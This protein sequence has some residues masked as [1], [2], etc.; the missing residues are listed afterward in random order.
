MGPGSLAPAQDLVTFRDVAVDFTQEEWGLLD[1]L[2]KK[3]YKEV[4]LENAQNLLSLGLPV[5]REDM[6]SYFKQREA[7]WLLDQ[8]GLRRCSL[9]REIQLEMTES[10]H[11]QRFMSPCDFVRNEIQ[12]THEKLHNSEKPN[13]CNQCGKSFKKK[14]SL[15]LHQRIHTGEKLYECNLCE[16]TFRERG[17]LTVHQRIHTGEKPYECNHC[18]KTFRE[19]GTLT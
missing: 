19:K 2:Q 17:Q 3:L 8:E 15:T 9:E 7:P 6:I 4:M 13:K 16:K 11:K 18:G 10:T 1:H 14:Q 5:S 12:A